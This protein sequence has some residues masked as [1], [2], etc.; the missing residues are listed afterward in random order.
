MKTISFAIPCYRSENTISYVI[1]EIKEVIRQ[2][3]RYDYE[4]VCVVDGSP[5]NVYDTLCSLAND[6]S[7]IK[8]INLSKNFG[9]ANAK[10]AALRFSTG[11][12]IVSLDDDG[13]CPMDRLLDLLAPLENGYDISMADYP[14]KKQSLF[15]N[16]GSD[17]N[18]ATARLILDVPKDFRS[19]NFYAIKKYVRNQMIKYNN[20]YPYADGLMSQ[21]THRIAYV[22]MEERNRMAGGT[23]YT[24]RKLVALWLNG[25]TAYSVVPLRISS[26]TGV[27][28]AILGFVFGIVTIVRR[29]TVPDISM[30]WSSIVSLILF[31]GGLMMMMLGMIGEYIGRIYISINNAPQYVVR[32]TV[33]IS[34][35]ELGEI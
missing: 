31:I 17:F 9:Q 35:D 7:K 1:Q 12:I 15:K 27:V 3:D 10:M 20:P 30:G 22:P 2:S 32:S 28:C 8:V 24:F 13:Q 25:F 19:S 4:I 21:V 34:G 11:D 16:L 26:I 29:I 5:D 6:D 33:N 23:G 14:V 18:K